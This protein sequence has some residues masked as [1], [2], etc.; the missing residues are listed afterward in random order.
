MIVRQARKRARFYRFTQ[1]GFP[2]PF[3]IASR[4]RQQNQ[5][6]HLGSGCLYGLHRSFSS[7]CYW[8][9]YCDLCQAWKP[10]NGTGTCHQ[11]GTALEPF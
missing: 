6:V 5:L 2:I 9:S 10:E 1:I 8:R 11:C 3:L 4:L 7:T